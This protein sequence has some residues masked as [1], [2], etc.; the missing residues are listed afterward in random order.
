MLKNIISC[1]GGQI[2]WCIQFFIGAPS[3]NTKK[4]LAEATLF[5]PFAKNE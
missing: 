2:E 4:Y 3:A 5:A 1:Q